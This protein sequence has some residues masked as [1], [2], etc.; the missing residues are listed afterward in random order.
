MLVWSACTQTISA[1]ARGSASPAADSANVKVRLVRP[2]RPSLTSTSKASSKRSGRRYSTSI[3]TVL[4]SAPL[5]FP[6][7][8]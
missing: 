6:I 5:V 3:R 7:A 8:V 1:V 4:K 2:I